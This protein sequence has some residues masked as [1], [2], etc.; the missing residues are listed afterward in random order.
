MSLKNLEYLIFQNVK[1]DDVDIGFI[2]RKLGLYLGNWIN[3][4]SLR[5]CS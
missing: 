5:H 1:L 3:T 4:Q 2:L